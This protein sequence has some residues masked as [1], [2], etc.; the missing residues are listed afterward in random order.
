MRI[1]APRA[2]KDAFDGLPLRQV[3]GK[4]DFHAGVHVPRD[5]ESVLPARRC[6]EGVDFGEWVARL[7]VDAGDEG[8]KG[9]GVGAEGGEEED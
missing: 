6:D 4:G 9:R 1:R 8:G 5:S 3:V 7:D 2:H